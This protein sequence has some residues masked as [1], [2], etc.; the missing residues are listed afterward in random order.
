MNNIQ[1]VI[2]ERNTKINKILVTLTDITGFDHSGKSLEAFHVA[3]T[4][5]KTHISETIRQV[6]QAVEEEVEGMKKNVTLDIKKIPDKDNKGLI[7]IN[8][9][10]LPAIMHN[11]REFMK[12]LRYER[13]YNSAISDI[14][15]LLKSAKENIK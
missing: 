11:A 9:E 2:E 13:D 12:D 6:L 4:E 8:A 5:L 14:Q 15:S 7:I 1:R 3:E 10:T